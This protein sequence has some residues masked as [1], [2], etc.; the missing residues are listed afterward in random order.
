MGIL[1]INI[2][3]GSMNKD[4]QNYNQNQNQKNFSKQNEMQNQID[5][6]EEEF[7]RRLEEQRQTYEAEKMMNQQ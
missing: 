3:L 2:R 5:K 6:L 1:T 7:N 4:N